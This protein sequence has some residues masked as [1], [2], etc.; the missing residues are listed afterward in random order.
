MEPKQK[1]EQDTTVGQE[2]FAPKTEYLDEKLLAYSQTDAYPFHMPG[3]KRQSMGNWTG[4]EI[5]ITEITGFDNLHHAEGILR[6]A[7]HRAAET[8]GADETFFLVN[9]STAGLLAAVCGT[10]KKGGRLLM[11]RNCHKAVYHAVYLMELKTTYLYPKQTA[12][13]IQGSIS[14]EQVETMLE[15]YPDTEAVLLTSPT[16]DGVLSDIA[17]IAEIVHAKGIPLIVDEAHGAHFGFSKGFPQK[18]LALGAD[19]CIESAHKTLPAYTQSALLH[20]RKNPWVDLERV[21]WYLGI[22]QSSSPSYILM[23]G[24]DRCTRILRE[25]GTE[26]FAAYEERLHDFYEKCKTLQRITVLSPDGKIGET[27]EKD[28]G[29]WDRDPSKILI[30]AERVGLHGQQLAELLTERYHLEMEMVSG[31]YVTALTTLM[32]TTEGFNRLFAALQEIDQRD[33]V[34]L[35]QGIFTTDEIYHRAEKVL[36]IAEAM[37]APKQTVSLM[38]SAESVSGEFVYLYPPGIPILAPGERVTEEILKT[39]RICQTRNM[40]VEGMKD[41]SGQ[42]IEVCT[43]L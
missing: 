40:E 42:R 18:A 36:E 41:Y 39:L 15:Q 38:E 13:G 22:Y 21:K 2:H 28:P 8:F 24:L 37:D 30:C 27:G 19:L 31:H 25:Q 1:T 7:Q 32:D 10:V 29:I 33:E 43:I 20:Y 12:F 11:A 5:D 26:L 17:A 14:P 3:H 4:E 23:A 16:Y 35:N 9:G 34:D 6:D